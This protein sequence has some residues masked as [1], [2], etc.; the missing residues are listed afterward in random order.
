M[1]KWTWRG[2]YIPANRSE[3]E[4]IRIQSEAERFPDPKGKEAS[5]GFYQLS[6]SEQ[7]NILKKRLKEYSKKVYRSMHKS[8]TETRNSTVCMRENPFYVDTVRAFRDRRY[9]YKGKLKEAQKN[10]EKTVE[11]YLVYCLHLTHSYI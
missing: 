8:L 2:E 9:L 6:Q 3:Y 7:Q 11:V 4:R 5:V 1:L 10:Y